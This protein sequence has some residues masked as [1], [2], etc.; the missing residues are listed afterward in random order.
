[1]T[2]LVLF[3]GSSILITMN[4]T[5]NEIFYSIQGESVHAGLPCVFVRLTGCN[6][7]CRYCDTRYAFNEGSTMAVGQI[8]DR[9]AS[10]GCSLVEITGGEP[11][12]Q[13]GTPE[14][15]TA[16]LAQ[17]HEVLVET[18]GSLN[19]DRVDRRCSR[20]MD[21]K[22]PSSGEASK[23]D[24]DNLARLT[25]NDQIKFVIGDEDD[26]RFA[27]QTLDR[28]PDVLPRDRI[29]FSNVA[30]QL[31]PDLL[32]RW[33]LDAHIR[34]RMQIQLHTVIWPNRDCGV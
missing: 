5:V 22:C 33:M 10:F 20:I 28:M 6:L 2:N 7:R 31:P 23:N 11:L 17:G 13:K 26:F 18:N 34:A 4:L 27:L 14:L 8:L 15:A 30:E 3:T 29:L 1:M 32:A 19:I 9:V 16:L 12:L 21:I 24:A 25:A